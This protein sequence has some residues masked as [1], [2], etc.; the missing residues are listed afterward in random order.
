[1]SIPRVGPIHPPPFAAPP[2]PPYL[3]DSGAC[4]G[5]NHYHNEY[6]A[7]ANVIPASHTIVASTLSSPFECCSRCKSES[8]CRGFNV[9]HSTGLCTFMLNADPLRRRT[10]SRH[11]VHVG[12][13][14]PPDQRTIGRVISPRPCALFYSNQQFPYFQ[15]YSGSQAYR[16]RAAPYPSGQPRGDM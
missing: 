10:G 6:I 5:F 9:E 13:V 2:P 7:T 3:P 11:P 14:Y 4:S 12:R 1:M 15:C 8:S 16:Y